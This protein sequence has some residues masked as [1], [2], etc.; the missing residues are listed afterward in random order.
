MEPLCLSH[1]NPLKSI[2]PHGKDEISA[3]ANVYASV[4]RAIVGVG[5]A[6]QDVVDSLNEGGVVGIAADT[7]LGT[8]GSAVQGIG[9]LFNLGRSSGDA[10]G[11]DGDSYDVGNALAADLGRA[12]GIVLTI[13]GTAQYSLGAKAPLYRAVS[14]AEMSSLAESGSFQPSPSGSMSKGFFFSK[15]DAEAFASQKSRI[16]GPHSVVSAEA[17]TQLVRSSPPHVAGEG[18]GVYIPNN[19]LSSVTPKVTPR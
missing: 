3:L 4:S 13:A 6:I 14:Q 15:G 2:D 18:P 7:A 17:P 16:D 8:A 12:S 11:S 1:G 10:I 9:D 19:R 5:S